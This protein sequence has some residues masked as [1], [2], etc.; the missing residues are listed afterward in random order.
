M[1]RSL[2]ELKNNLDKKISEFLDY[3]I[4]NGGP[5]PHEY[6]ELTS[7]VNNLDHADIDDFREKI[8]T[9]LNENTLIGHGF[10]KPYGYPGDFILLDKIYQFDVNEDPRYKNWDLFFQ[11][12]PGAYAVRNRKD[13]FIEYCRNLALRKEECKSSDSGFGSGFRCL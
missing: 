12:Q 3:L 1:K 7:I 9:I 8:K 4:K 2:L 5:E 11:N 13:F 6:A 10:V